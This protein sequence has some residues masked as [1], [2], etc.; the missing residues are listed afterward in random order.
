MK[1][2]EENKIEISDFFLKDE[3]LLAAR[4]P[5][6]Q[7]FFKIFIRNLMICGLKD[8]IITLEVNGSRLKQYSYKL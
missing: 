6:T 4:E 2:L 8:L 3:E 5:F 1:S 7:V